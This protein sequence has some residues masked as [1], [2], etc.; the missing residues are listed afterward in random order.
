MPRDQRLEKPSA[1][2]TLGSGTSS[3]RTNQRLNEFNVRA[4]ESCGLNFSENAQGLKT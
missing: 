2:P 4:I 3:A 1:N